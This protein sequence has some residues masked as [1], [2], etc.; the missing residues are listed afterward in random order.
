MRINSLKIHNFKIFDDAEF[1]FRENATNV[2]CGKNGFG[3]TS[4]FDAIELLLTGKIKRYADWVANYHNAQLYFKS[5]KP[6]VH[7]ENTEDVYI[8]AEIE[9][10]DGVFCFTRRELVSKIHNPLNFDEI[11]NDISCVR[12]GGE[13]EERIPDEFLL[14]ASTY[15]RLNYQSQEQATDFLK[16][17]EEDRTSAISILFQTKEYD[18]VI[19]KLT[20]ARKSLQSILRDYE[21]KNKA[22]QDDIKKVSQSFTFQVSRS[23]P[24]IYRRLF[25]EEGIEWDKEAPSS[26]ISS[27]EAVIAKDG[28][29]YKLQYYFHHRKEY[30]QYRTNKS[31][32]HCIANNLHIVVA[33]LLKG[34]SQERLIK[35]YECFK[36]HYGDL[37]TVVSVDNISN[38]SIK[39]TPLLS[40]YLEEGA[41]A[42]LETRRQTIVRTINSCNAL[43]NAYS[44]I[45]QSRTVIIPEIS[46]L[47]K[48]DCPLCGHSY[49]T[50]EDL[51]QAITD[52][53]SILKEHAK[54]VGESVFMMLSDFKKAFYE[55]IISPL[56]Q[57]FDDKGITEDDYQQYLSC[58]KQEDDNDVSA[59]RHEVES[60]ID[61][62]K[63]VDELK[64][65]IYDYV[66]SLKKDID[67]GLD[68]KTLSSMHSRYSKYIGEDISDEKIECK[69][70][71]LL[72]ICSRQSAEYYE[73]KKNELKQI[74]KVVHAADSKSNALQ[75]L[76]DKIK[77]QRSEYIT[78]VISN[79]EIL[80]YI[81]SGRIMQDSFYGRGV[82][83]KMC[84]SVTAKQRLLF[85]SGRYDSEVDV[86]YNL[87]SGQMVS[88]A[89]AFLLSL[90]KL[91]DT[92]KFLAIDDPVQ[93]IDDINFWGLIE[94]IRH[95]FHDYNLF[96]STHEDNYASLL[97][98][99]FANLGIPAKAYDMKNQR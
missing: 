70:H 57:Y 44:R 27:L 82:F 94:T 68:V 21:S 11:F 99:K 88:I 17:K 56:Q 89:I 34:V 16:S 81:Y 42:E 61:T 5:G 54:E 76:I 72:D 75:A 33:C 1:A 18:D 23:E 6:L 37:Y 47:S 7:D 98:Y 93:T 40:G 28:V 43:Q 77:K 45:L 15:N 41:V 97:R 9:L 24:I 32:E 36:Q 60:F 63:T 86:L 51:R 2:F 79:I 19:D 49:Q 39:T 46:N 30:K 14:F 25:A 50:K 29:L 26:S 80:F 31:V 4:V 66:K 74:Q 87:S 10:A 95:E 12:R 62:S 53:G 13:T 38:V 78:S 69:R 91:Y 52:Y 83:M 71:Y 22:I 20:K 3:K 84:T 67:A 90:N 48:S 8:S 85:V 73:S 96:V 59:I 64:D 55:K 92:G 65:D 35:E 58:K